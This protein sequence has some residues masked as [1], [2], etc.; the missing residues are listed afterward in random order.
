MFWIMRDGSLGP[1]GASL[2]WRPETAWLIQRRK[3]L[4]FTE[5]VAENLCAEALPAP[6]AQLRRRGVTLIPHG[7]SLSLGSAEGYSRAAL[8]HLARI[9]EQLEAPFVS[10]HVAFV[11]A[12][13]V[14]AGHL[15]PVARSE[16]MLDI[17]SENMRQV[18]RVLPVPLA[19]E[20][21]A[22]LFEWPDAEMDEATFVGELLDRTGSR[23]VL[24]LANLYANAQNHGSD[25]VSLLG[26]LSRGQVAYVHVAGGRWESGLYH[27]THGA[28]LDT[29]V[30][31]LL[32]E[33][34]ER[35]G[36]LP[37][38]IERDDDFGTRWALEAELDE[39][40][41][42]VARAAEPDVSRAPQVPAAPGRA[43]LRG[44]AD[45]AREQQLALV[46]SLVLEQAA[47]PGFDPRRLELASR[48]LG[49]KVA[50]TLAKRTQS[51][52]RRARAAGA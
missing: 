46:E 24:D 14:E 23:V 2:G 26:R 35:F 6:L 39:V 19:L 15:L 40:A 27:D 48:A 49:H 10:E 13:G 9:A 37:V 12:G 1:H 32:A 41:A 5:V 31:A 22:T 51:A 11:R 25:P 52:R 47:P 29:P 45:S 50:R 3:D 4:A 16:R 42:L 8:D 38:L 33:T 43:L 30:L 17:I 34:L 20:H 28:R 36:P 21:I 7:V 44:S 18:R